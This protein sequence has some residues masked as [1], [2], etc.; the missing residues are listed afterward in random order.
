MA[1]ATVPTSTTAPAIQSCSSKVAGPVGELSVGGEVP[2]C[3]HTTHE[4]QSVCEDQIRERAYLKWEAAGYPEGDGV[5]FWLSAEQE[6][7]SEA[8]AE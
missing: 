2:C 7:L 1:T 3:E 8:N 4:G 6:L 5:E